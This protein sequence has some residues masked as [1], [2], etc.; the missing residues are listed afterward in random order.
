[1]AHDSTKLTHQKTYKTIERTQELIAKLTRNAVVSFLG[2]NGF[3]FL[4][5]AQTPEG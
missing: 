2:F 5:S 3:K 4:P 1:M